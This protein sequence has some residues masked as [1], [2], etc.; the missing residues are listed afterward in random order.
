MNASPSMAARLGLRSIP[1]EIRKDT[2]ARNPIK[3]GPELS[4]RP[5]FFGANFDAEK[6]KGTKVQTDKE[7]FQANP[8]I[9]THKPQKKDATQIGKD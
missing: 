4:E 2:P 7:T 5:H 9:I 8:Y 1:R 6:K 3:T